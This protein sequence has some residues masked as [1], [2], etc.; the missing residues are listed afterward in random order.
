MK[1]LVLCGL[2]V[3]A[4]SSF[5]F[6]LPFETWYSFGVPFGNYFENGKGLDNTYTGSVGVGFSMYHFSDSRN[7]GLFTDV[8]ILA[9]VIDNMNNS[10]ALFQNGLILGPGFRYSINHD[11]AMY[12]G[13]GFNASWFFAGK[14]HDPA[15]S[16]FLD[17]RTG[18]GIGGNAGIKYN[19]SD[20][21][22][23]SIGTTLAYLFAGNRTL[24]S[25]DDDWTTTVQKSSGWIPN[26]SMFGIGPYIA[27]GFNF[28]G[29]ST[30]ALG[31]PGRK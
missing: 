9:S 3:F 18:L 7:V 29:Q 13:L 23:V 22:Y 26:Y 4:G 19:V 14:P 11:L 16:E 2:L 6:S 24:E 15:G 1:R 25:S 27:C 30:S 31:R 21:V 17:T 12:F 8:N 20:T 28:Y 10:N 5:V